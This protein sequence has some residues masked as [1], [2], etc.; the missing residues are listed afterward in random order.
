MKL[1]NEILN[2]Q[3]FLNIEKLYITWTKVNDISYLKNIKKLSINEY[4]T[5]EQINKFDLI[6]LDTRTNDNVKCIN[7]PNLTKLNISRNQYKIDLLKMPKITN[8]SLGTYGKNF[9]DDDSIKHLKLQK[10]QF[11]FRKQYK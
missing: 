3:I 11:N 10:L 1:T 7:Q 2:Q 9:Y 6:S 4:I 5:D 8:L